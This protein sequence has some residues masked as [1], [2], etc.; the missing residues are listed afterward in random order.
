MTPGR[1][2]DR[3]LL[4]LFRLLLRAFPSRFRKLHGEGMEEMF[5]D[6]IRQARQRGQRV[7]EITGDRRGV[8]QQG[9]TPAHQRA[10]QFRLVEQ[11]VDAELDHGCSFRRAL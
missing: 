3:I 8:R 10:P 11:V 6:E 9:D 2:P 4:Y 7:D 5:L 1:D